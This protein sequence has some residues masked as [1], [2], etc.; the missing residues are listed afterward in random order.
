MET[1]KKTKGGSTCGGVAQPPVL[2]STIPHAT[3]LLTSRQTVRKVSQAIWDSGPFTPLAKATGVGSAGASAEV[4]R[5]VYRT[6]AQSEAS[7]M[8]TIP[9]YACAVALAECSQ[10]AAAVKGRYRTPSHLKRVSRDPPASQD[11]NGSAPLSLR[12][13][14]GQ[15]SQ[16]DPTALPEPLASANP[17]LHI[18]HLPATMPISQVLRDRWS[19]G[20]WPLAG[21]LRTP[22]TPPLAALSDDA[23]AAACGAMRRALQAAKDA[24]S[25]AAAALFSPTTGAVLAVGVA[26]T[27]RSPLAHPIIDL[28]RAWG[29]TCQRQQAAQAYSVY[30]MTGLV[31]VLTVE[32]CAM[33]TMALLHSRVSAVFLAPHRHAAVA[34]A[35]E[36]SSTKIVRS[37]TS[38]AHT[39][40]C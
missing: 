16:V 12:L 25:P 23:F 36:S 7:G 8:T 20:T 19:Y 5:A 35:A 29:R 2:L 27:S 37:T 10:W 9:F 15:V 1:K 31:A 21:R 24:E 39:V 34:L 6:V 26:G 28:A 40:D 3:P 13:L 11:G 18:V 17:T 4:R 32:P 38:L 22:S 33:C 30:L 14:I